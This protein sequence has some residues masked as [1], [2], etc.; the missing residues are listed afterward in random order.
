MNKLHCPGATRSRIQRYERRDA[1]KP[2]WR[3][4]CVIHLEVQVLK[5]AR[6]H[7]LRSRSSLTHDI[8]APGQ[9]SPR[10]RLGVRA[11]PPSTTPSRGI[12][13]KRHWHAQ[14]GWPGSIC[15]PAKSP[16][17]RQG[18][19]P[20]GRRRLLRHARRCR[21]ERVMTDNGSCYR[22]KTFRA[23]CKRLGLRQVFDQALH[24]RGPTERLNALSKQASARSW[25][26]AHA[27]RPY[28]DQRSAEMLHHGC[29]DDVN[30]HRPH[31]SLKANTPISRLGLAENN[32]LRLH[33]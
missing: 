14:P 26:Y 32:L 6:P 13:Y 4:F 2:R 22:S 3:K 29:I 27:Y 33:N 30:W 11:M 8:P 23:A 31:G 7:R 17:A 25:A 16:R 10:H 28:S 15:S 19:L 21:I 18:A 12:A 1:G 20:A 5:K 24:A 9:S